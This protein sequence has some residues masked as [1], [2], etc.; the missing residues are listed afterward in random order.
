[1]TNFNYPQKQDLIKKFDD[2]LFVSAVFAQV[3]KE[4]LKIGLAL[5]FSEE[6]LLSFASFS[7]RLSGELDAILQHSKQLFNQLLYSIDLQEEAVNRII[8]HEIEPLPHLAELILLRS[9]QKVCFRMQ[10]KANIKH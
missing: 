2:S 8:Q 10:Y 5:T 1:M 9:G 7:A 3:E 4:F 6:D